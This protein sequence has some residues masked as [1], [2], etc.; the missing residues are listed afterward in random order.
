MDL[1]Q[2]CDQ[3]FQI[4]IRVRVLFLLVVEFVHFGHHKELRVLINLFV[5]AV[6]HDLPLVQRCGHAPDF[7]NVARPRIESQVFHQR[8]HG[9]FDH[10]LV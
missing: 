10:P 4:D 3:K 7:V 9:F 6:P 8:D 2:S 1:P 5:F